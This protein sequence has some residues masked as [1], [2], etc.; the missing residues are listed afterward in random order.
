[1]DVDNQTDRPM[2]VDVCL[3]QVGNQPLG[4]DQVFLAPDYIGLF[5]IYTIVGAAKSFAQRM[6]GELLF[7][8]YGYSY[9]AVDRQCIL[10]RSSVSR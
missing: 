9:S 4:L 8:V 7:V 10:L 5:W 1:M 6:A 2:D 3:H